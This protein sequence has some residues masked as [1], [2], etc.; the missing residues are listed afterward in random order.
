M[1]KNY[2]VK[3]SVGDPVTLLSIGDGGSVNAV[4][5]RIVGVYELKYYRNVF[6]YINLM[7]IATYSQLYNYTGVDASSMPV[8]YN[9]ALALDSEDVIFGLADSNIG[10]LDTKKSGAQGTER[11]CHDRCKT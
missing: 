2:S 9:N 6:N 5:S 3:L 1:K 11:I 4:P 10:A 7:D 8:V